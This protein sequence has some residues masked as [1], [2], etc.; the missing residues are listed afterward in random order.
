M[1]LSTNITYLRK[2][3]GT[4]KER[5]IVECARIIKNAGFRYIDFNPTR[6]LKEDNWKEFILQ[7]REELDKLGLKVNQAHAP[8]NYRKMAPE[9][10]EEQMKRSFEAAHLLGADYHI[11]HADKYIPD[12]NGFNP[13]KAVEE[14]Y[15]FYAPYVEYAGSVGMGVAVENLFE[16]VGTVKRGRFSAYVEEQ[17]AIIDRF[18]DKNVTACWDIG[19][20]KVSYG[21]EHLSAM[22]QLGSLLTCTHIHDNLYRTDFHQNIYFGDSD[23]DEV[24]R[25]LREMDYKGFFT[26]EMVYGVFPD[27]LVQKYMD[28]FY[29]TGMYLLN[30]N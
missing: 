17:L 20:G 30:H 13:D 23:W 19:H 15:E 4:T 28:L 21:K 18:H 6:F 25:T 16:T 11:I 22:K 29:E 7:T 14:I 5:D 26:F 24:V 9:A 1:E 10:F 3:L 27:A 2:Q 12:D 8:Y